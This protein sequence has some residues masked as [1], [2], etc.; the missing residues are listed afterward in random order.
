[1]YNF[2]NDPTGPDAILFIVVVCRKFCGGKRVR[3]YNRKD[4]GNTLRRAVL[5]KSAVLIKKSSVVP[6]SDLMSI[7]IILETSLSGSVKNGMQEFIDKPLSSP[8]ILSLRIPP[9]NLCLHLA[10]RRQPCASGRSIRVTC[11]LTYGLK[12]TIH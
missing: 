11:S 1:M 9:Q 7:V 8:C 6:S 5:N 12:K 4:G 3:I 10:S 2:L